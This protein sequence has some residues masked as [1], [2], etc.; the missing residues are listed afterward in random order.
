MECENKVGE[1][2]QIVSLDPGLFNIT[3][4]EFLESMSTACGVLNSQGRKRNTNVQFQPARTC[5]SYLY[6]T[7][8]VLRSCTATYTVRLLFVETKCLCDK[9]S[10]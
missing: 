8:P 1:P 2:W 3:C 5:K 9:M 7:Q 6:L 4:F 10:N